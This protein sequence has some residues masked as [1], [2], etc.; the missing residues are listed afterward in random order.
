MTNF[1][2]TGCY[3][4]GNR[5]RLICS[6]DGTML[7]NFLLGLNRKLNIE[8]LIPRIEVNGVKTHMHIGCFCKYFI[9]K[10]SKLKEKVE[11]T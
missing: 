5:K 1:N 3:W 6:K 11:F 7:Q 10:P 8:E 4:C 2:T 9:E